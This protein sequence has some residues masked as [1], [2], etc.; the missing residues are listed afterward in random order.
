M[1]SIT[2]EEFFVLLALRL[3]CCFNKVR[4]NIP[5]FERRKS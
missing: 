4:T 5:S 2:S 3:L 1:L